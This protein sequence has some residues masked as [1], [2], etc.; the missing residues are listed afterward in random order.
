MLLSLKKKKQKVA[1]NRVFRPRDDIEYPFQ[2]TNRNDQLI[3]TYHDKNCYVTFNYHEDGLIATIQMFECNSKGKKRGG[4]LGKKLLY[5]VLKNIRDSTRV[6]KIELIPVP[7]GKNSNNNE[8]KLVKYYEKLGFKQDNS[9]GHMNAMLDDLLIILN[10]K[11][12]TKGLGRKKKTKKKIKI[13][14][15]K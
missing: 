3:I 14:I 10:P 15:K 4:G 2:H 7:T 13:K 12:T 9:T 6:I 11:N 8:S 1:T 5:N